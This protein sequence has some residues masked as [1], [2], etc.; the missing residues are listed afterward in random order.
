MKSKSSLEKAAILMIA[1]GEDLASEI[2]AQLAQDEAIRLARAISQIGKVNEHDIDEVTR[3]FE[4]LLSKKDLG[5][6]GSPDLARRL[7]QKAF[8]SEDAAR[9][10]ADFDAAS[11]LLKRALADMSGNDLTRLISGEHPQTQA[12][13]ITHLDP[14]TGGSVLKS[15]PPQLRTEI[16]MR[17]A[18]L[19][20]VS[21]EVLTDLLDVVS[22]FKAQNQHLGKKRLG[23]LENLVAL[24]RSLDQ[25]AADAMLKDLA[26]RDPSLAEQVRAQLFTFNDLIL[27][28]SRGIQALLKEV[29]QGVLILALRGAPDTVLNHVLGNMSARAKDLIVDEIRAGKAQKASDISK[30]RHDIADLALKLE[31]EGKLHIKGRGEQLV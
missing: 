7:F 31:A 12:L 2:F 18:Q 10:T 8:K 22:A 19:E 28:D 17:V 26:A 24:I 13:L 14:K 21:Q 25:N 6:T 9:L 16:M 15:I 11:P 29:K 3:E 20:T 27:I 30:A 1:L 23:G 4:E 5:F